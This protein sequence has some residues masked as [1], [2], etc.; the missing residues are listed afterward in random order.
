MKILQVTNGFPPTA[1]AGVEQY[2]YQLGQA[3]NDQH[4]VRV[5]CRE[6]DPA[7]RDYEV[8]DGVYDGLV[9]RRVVND[10]QHADHVRDFYVDRRIERIFRSTLAE[11]KPDLIHFQHCIG[12]SAS[13]LEV[14]K[15]EQIP[16]LLTLHD[17]WY[18]CSQVQLYD[19]RGQIC[20][21]P[22]SDGDC[23]DCMASPRGVFGSFRRTR[24]YRFVRSR[25]D[26]STK[27]WIL[28]AVSRI[29][30]S[31]PPPDPEAALSP[32]VDRTEYM[33]SLLRA[34]PRILVPSRFVRDMYVKHGVPRGRVKVLPLGLD[35]T[36]WD[37]APRGDETVDAQAPRVGY[38]G[39]LLRHKGVH[40]LMQA[41]QRLEIPKATLR[42]H[43]FPIPGDPYIDEL[44]GLADQDPR[45]Q[46]MGRYEHRN[47]PTLLSDVDIVVIPSLWH[48]T[49]SIVAREALL[50]GAPVIAS[51][52]GA[53]PEVIRDGENGCLVPPGDVT[54]LHGALSNTLTHP[55]R[56]MRLREGARDS[57]GFVKSIGD[58]ALEIESEYQ[59][60]RQ[61]ATSPRA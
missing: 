30:P 7:R 38:I 43:G 5:F 45:I 13:M 10:F 48:E 11:W 22:M 47:L 9:V 14:A 60:L 32:F 46:L 15:Q 41:F 3:L 12:L 1:S 18:L 37:S 28:S 8:I 39:T 57:R 19:H 23:Y 50:A 36:D 33:L 17:Y 35:L 29:M 51:R 59:D 61:G 16:H 25:L 6:S 40:V 21:G 34:V 27:R 42:V 53:I 4:D 55:D 31:V 20:E 52:V 2:T 54:A 58:H 24:L 49:F 56:L 44:G 26:E